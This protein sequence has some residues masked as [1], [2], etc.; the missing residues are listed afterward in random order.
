MWQKK[1]NPEQAIQQEVL[2]Q[3]HQKQHYYQL[4]N[5]KRSKKIEIILPK[6]TT[7]KIPVNS[8]QFDENKAKC[9]VI[10]DGGDDPDVTHGAEIIVE[11][12]FNRKQK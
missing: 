2:L 8:C 5:N 7:I 4:L 11:L 10:K 9:S 1:K 3:Q 6:K 12:T